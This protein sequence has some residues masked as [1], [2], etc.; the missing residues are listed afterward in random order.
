MERTQAGSGKPRIMIS[1]GSGLLGMELRRLDPDIIAPPRSVMDV[2]DRKQVADC[3]ERVRPQI[4]VHCA[5]I[6]GTVRCREDPLLAMQVNVGGVLNTVE[7]AMEYSCRYVFISSEYVFE[8][9]TLKSGRYVE[10]DP[11]N[12]GSINARS[13]IA[14]EM[15]AGAHPNHLIIRTSFFGRSFLG[16]HARSYKGAFCDQ[17]TSRDFVDVLAPQYLQAA[18]SD[19]TGVIHIGTGRKSQY[20]LLSEAFPDVK[21]ITRADVDPMLP[22]DCSIDCSRWAAI[23]ESMKLVEED[24]P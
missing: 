9:N 24:V 16:L 14:G 3:F 15:V 10:T 17:Y 20:E 4:F 2:T 21:P 12:G 18:R 6:I 22:A 5:A 8:T 13:K 19:L 1:G 11:L 7:A 23:R